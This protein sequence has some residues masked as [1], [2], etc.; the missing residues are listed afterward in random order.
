[1]IRTLIRT[2]ITCLHL[3]APTGQ[4]AWGV[5]GCPDVATE[6]RVG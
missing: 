1:M 2:L 5:L 4:P 3:N 6:V